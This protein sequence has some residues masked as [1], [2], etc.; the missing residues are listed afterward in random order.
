MTELQ[1]K[2]VNMLY[3][4]H[5][6]CMTEGLRYYTLGGTALGCA[7]HEGFIPWDDDIDVGMPRSDYEK[8]QAI[9]KEKKYDIYLF[10]FPGCKDDFSYEFAKMYDT[11]TTLIENTKYKTKRGIYID[12][13]PLDGAG[14]T[15]EEAKK[16][17]RKIDMI[18]KVYSTRI[19]T[20]RKER[21][22]LKNLAI[23]SSGL[24]PDIFLDYKKLIR[25][26]EKRCSKLD[27][28]EYQFV[29]NYYG[30]WR[31]KEIADKTWFGTQ[32]IYKF[33]DIEVCGPQQID[34][35]L[36]ALYGDWK[37]LPPIEKR[38]THHDYIVL[39]LEHSYLE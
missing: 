28:D 1:K 39:D 20:V 32:K 29:A 4:F 5:S 23:I 15:Y 3:T 6:I 36:S 7:R 24:L 14:Q 25:I 2:L 30:A 10:E 22:S 11:S 31:V 27:Y 34:L 9:T 37:K 26:L 12:I 17:F 19:C 13:F 38:K 8:L 16:N 21:S 33:E 18:Y 35:Y